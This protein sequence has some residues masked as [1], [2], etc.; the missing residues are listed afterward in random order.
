MGRDPIIQKAFETADDSLHGIIGYH[1]YV[2]AMQKAVDREEMLQYLPE[3]S[4][5]TT[6]SW[7]RYYQKRDLIGTFEQPI[8]ARVFHGVSGSV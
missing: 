1:M 8:R 2:S 5:Q 4:F 6:F 7:V 3:G